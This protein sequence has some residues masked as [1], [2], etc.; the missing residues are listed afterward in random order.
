M[1]KAV[2][3]DADGVV[4]DTH[5][6]YLLAD[7]IFLKNHARDTNPENFDHLL[8]GVSLEDGT[9]ILQ[10]LFGIQGNSNDLLLERIEIIKT[11]YKK[12]NFIPGFLGFFNKI[13]PGYKVAIATSSNTEFFSIA[14][15]ELGLHKLFDDH[16]YFLKDANDISKPAPDIYLFAARQLNTNPS[17]CL[18]VEDAP[19]GIQ[20]GKKAGMKVVGLSSSHNR[21]ILK[22]ADQIVDSFDQINLE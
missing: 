4:I 10:N 5:E 20:S 22:E 15:N 16:I 6:I 18:V 17:E 1:I 13:K 14:D 9:K 11:L 2:I 12:V 8:N 19:S 21:E 7:Q 3:F